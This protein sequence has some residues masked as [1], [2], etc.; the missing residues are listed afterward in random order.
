MKKIAAFSYSARNWGGSF[1]YSL[2]ILRA[3]QESVS[4]QY[5]LCFF[6]TE[7]DCDGLDREFGFKS[8][9]VKRGW[10]FLKFVR[11]FCRWMSRFFPKSFWRRWAYVDEVSY[12][13]WRYNPDVCICLNQVFIPL[14]AKTIK[15]APVHD[16]MH[17]YLAKFPEVGMVDE[18]VY[19]EFVLHNFIKYYDILVDS[20]VG[21][22]HVLECYKADANRIHVLPFIPSP[23]LRSASRKPKALAESPLGP[24]I[25]YPAQ[26]WAHKNHQT[27][28]RAL[29]LLHNEQQ[30]IHAV[31]CGSQK[32]DGFERLQSV[33]N[34]IGLS[35]YVHCI[36]YVADVELKWLYENAVCMVMPTFFGPTNIPPLEA[37]QYGCP[38]ATSG[39]FGIPAQLGKAALYFDPNDPQEIAQCIKKILTDENARS[40]LVEEGY[41]LCKSWNED[42]F[43]ERFSSIFRHIIDRNADNM[44]R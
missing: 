18:Y 8:V 20:D 44:Q 1:Q 34:E 10:L 35:D 23:L 14:P 32:Q 21:K 25:V 22:G 28:V 12:A 7:P 3:L 19:R 30:Y 4:D 36:G 29:K 24:F 9:F 39:I 38:V 42:A 37:I 2:S 5:E 13:I 15:I 26:F 31:F 11:L 43:K 27:L 33:V 17:R 6:Y 41:L 40:S 16:L